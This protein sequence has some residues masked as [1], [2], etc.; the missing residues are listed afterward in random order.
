MT[1]RILG[2]DPS[3]RATGMALLSYTQGEPIKVSHCQTITVP[4]SFKGKEAIL[5][6]M[7]LLQVQYKK[8]ESYQ[9]ADQVIIE[10][11]PTIFNPKFPASALL[12]IAHISGASLVIFGLE[13][14]FLLYP[15][16]WNK[17]RKKQ[18]THEK[19]IEEIGSPDTWHF[20]HKIKSECH[21]EHILDA[22][23]MALFWLKQNYIEDF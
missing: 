22:V 3:T 10:G 19:I 7:E 23:G 8:V 15:A 13:K 16:E 20:A 11:P 18:V 21:I 6:M 14:S 12:P 4:T 1:V 2:I 17:A 5:K 9:Q